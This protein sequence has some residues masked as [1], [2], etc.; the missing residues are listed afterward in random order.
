MQRTYRVPV[1]RI[2]L[3]G[4]LALLVL[5]AYPGTSIAGGGSESTRP[6]F[7]AT[8]GLLQQGAGYGAN[9]AQ[10]ARVRALQ[11]QLHTLG[12][13]PG[14]VDGLFGPRTEAAL[15][16]FQTQAGIA[17]DGIAGPQTR[18]ALKRAI[19]S[20]LRR[21]AGYAQPAGSPRVR[22]VQRQLREHGFRPGPVDGLF[23]PR[24]EA[25]LKRFQ[26]AD[27]LAANGVVTRRT[28][29]RLAGAGPAAPNTQT[30]ATSEPERRQT[31]DRPSQATP[32]PG[33]ESPGRPVASVESEEEDAGG[34][35]LPIVIIAALIAL[36]VG[37]I[38]GFM[39]GQLRPGVMGSAV[40]LAH[41]VVAQ[42]WTRT[43]SIGHFS[44]HVHALVVDRGGLFRSP[45]TRYLVS[46]PGIRGPFWVTHEEVS[47]LAGA[48]VA[49]ERAQPGVAGE[50][51]VVVLGYVSVRDAGQLESIH[52]QEQADAIASHCSEQGWQL[53]EVIRDVER[54][55]TK[56]LDRP[57][58][59]YAL[60]RI[61]RGEASCLVVSQLGRL[62][63]SAVELRRVIEWLERSQSRLVALDVELDT[64]SP[65]ARVAVNAL[66]ELG[67][68]E[69]VPVA[70]RTPARVA[71][72]R[73]TRAGTAQRAGDDPAAVRD[74]IATMR[75]EGMTL[76]AIAD[77]LNEE[78]V[79]TLGGG[80]H[81]RP[82][83]VRYAAGAGR[84]RSQTLG[85]NG[86]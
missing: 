5:L 62:S 43:R 28:G 61:G 4:L 8:G 72:L 18:K 3:V 75:A 67:N 77:Q 30:P 22:T 10:A 56:A 50:D 84:P 44:G 59:R 78:G 29:R 47:R 27:G 23:G 80:T 33:A 73:A 81:W 69:A 14:P 20:P 1:A 25:A 39:L 17:V 35:D 54:P 19:A 55:T 58:L 63:H 2:G 38:G 70:E 24:T 12:W 82:S 86:S 9:D 57:G 79:P 51:E 52:M 71:A 31:P 21:G 37:V 45:E 15:L 42:G 40:P 11:R 76:Q 49:E 13:Q 48:P 41:G 7:E 68:W 46:D 65:D 85:G 66:I 6:G 64:A 36:I 16:R 26:R 60:E 32:R 74:R 53:L 34:V 83:S